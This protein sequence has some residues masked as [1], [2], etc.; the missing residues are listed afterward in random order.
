[1]KTHKYVKY[2]LVFSKVADSNNINNLLPRTGGC[3]TLVGF[4]AVQD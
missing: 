2:V 4:G 1:M 3:V